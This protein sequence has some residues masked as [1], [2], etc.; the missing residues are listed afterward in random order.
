M[1]ICDFQ[2]HRIYATAAPAAYWRIRQGGM[3]GAGV[4]IRSGQCPTKS[5]LKP[6]MRKPER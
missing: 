3:G 2:I 6:L 5:S 1:A 4:Q